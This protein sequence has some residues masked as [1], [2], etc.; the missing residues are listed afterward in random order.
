[1]VAVEDGHVGGIQGIQRGV[2][3]A[4]LGVG[5]V[6]AC[7]VSNAGFEGKLA[8]LLA[9][10]VIQNVDVQFV[11]GP[12]HVERAQRGVAHHL[13]RLVV[14]GNQDIDVRP[15]FFVVGKHYGRAPQRPD[16]L[17][18]SQEEDDKGVGFGQEKAKNEECVDHAPVIGRI[19]EKLDG[20]RDAPVAIAEGAEHR[21]HHQR[22][23]DQVRVR[24]A[25]QRQGHQQ[26]EKTADGL[27]RPG[28]GAARPGS[29]RPLPPPG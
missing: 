22:Q 15:F 19:A 3:V 9:A 26:G 24:T 8:E 23:R 2:D 21:H 27:L 18:V 25:R 28:H 1:M 5:I 6:V 7:L 12:V 13:Q 11:R 4:R 17:K 10:S 20:S 29:K 16:G 14:G